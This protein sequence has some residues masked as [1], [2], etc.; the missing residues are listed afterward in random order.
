VYQRRVVQ[1]SEYLHGLVP[2]QLTVV[3]HWLA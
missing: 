2:P 3:S 1:F